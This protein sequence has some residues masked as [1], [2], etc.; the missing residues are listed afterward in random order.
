MPY[1]FSQTRVMVRHVRAPAWSPLKKEE[2]CTVG[3]DAFSRQLEIVCV[4]FDADAVASPPRTSEIR[5]SCSHKGIQYSISCK[6]EH[7]NQSFSQLE[8]IR[9]RVLWTRSSRK[10]TPDLAKPPL[11]IIFANDA[12]DSFATAR[13]AVAAWLPLH[14]HEFNIVLD[15]RVWFV[16]FAQEP[17]PASHFVLCIRDLMPD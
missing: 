9:R 2:I 16:R 15:D 1:C 3:R 14:K 17:A 13:T 10:I 6:G 5:R 12:E 8:R 11:I 7:A 4:H